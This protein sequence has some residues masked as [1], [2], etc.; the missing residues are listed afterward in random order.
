[1]VPKRRAVLAG[2]IG[3]DWSKTGDGGFIPRYQALIGPVAD[4]EGKGLEGPTTG[5]M[6]LARFLIGEQLS[7]EAIGVLDDAFRTPSRP[8]R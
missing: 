5:H 7:F 3:D 4:E 2:L 1:M 6:A 8:G